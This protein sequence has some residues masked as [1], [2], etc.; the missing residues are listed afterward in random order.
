MTGPFV[1]VFRP[2]EGAALDLASLESVATAHD[3][4]LGA[5]MRATAPGANGMVLEGLELEGDW[6]AVGPPGT[7]RPDSKAEGATV[8]PGTVLLTGRDG[9]KFLIEIKE[10]LFTRW[11]T[12]AG[13]AVQGVLVLVPEAQQESLQG[14][15]SVAR[16]RVSVVMGFVKPNMINEPHVLPL[17]SSLG[18]GRDWVTDLTRVWQPDHPAIESLLKRFESLERLVWR[19][20]PEGS[21][22]E[23]QVLGRNWVRY[24]TMAAASLQ[25]A[26]MVLQAK[27]STTLDRVRLLN[28]LFEQLNISVERAANELLQLIGA[29]EGAGPYGAVGAKALKDRS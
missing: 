20:E 18:N 8:G 25:A 6:S 9:R 1:D 27:S 16:Q 22:W 21:V 5:F 29:E 23:R 26:R 7:V 4:L 3:Q 15:L 10:S 19:A 13:P 14:T 12:D 24:Q 11:P 2:V 17:A 28:G